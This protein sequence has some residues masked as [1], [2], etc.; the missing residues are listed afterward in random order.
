MLMTAALIGPAHGLR[1][2]VILDIRSDD[3]ELFI[4]GTVFETS[5]QSMPELTLRSIR[6]HKERVVALFEEVSDREGADALR[7]VRLLTDEREEEDAWYPHQLKGL[8]ALDLQGQT[9]GTVKGI[10]M[11]AAQDLLLVATQSGV[12]MVPFVHQIVPEVDVEGGTVTIDPLP[13][14]FDDDAVEAR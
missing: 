4:S 6:Q 5:E 3:P 2:E 14:L 10:Q 8:Q 1:G 7:G 12:V 13:G 9:L 11:G